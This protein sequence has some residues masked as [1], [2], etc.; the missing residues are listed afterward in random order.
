MIYI[1]NDLP[2]EYTGSV[3]TAK[4]KGTIAKAKA[5]A[6]QGIPHIINIAKGKFFRANNGDNNVFHAS[7]IIRHAQNGKMYLYDIIDIKKET[8]NPLGL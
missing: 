4:L 3:Y 2:D 7:L 5:N 6:T 8:G 1:G